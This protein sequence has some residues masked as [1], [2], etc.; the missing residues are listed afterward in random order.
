MVEAGNNI[1]DTAWRLVVK[2]PGGTAMATANPTA[3]Q[4]EADDLQPRRP[5]RRWRLPKKALVLVLGTAIVLLLLAR[6]DWSGFYTRGRLKE[7]VRYDAVNGLRHTRSVSGTRHLYAKAGQ[8]IE[9][10]YQAILTH[11]TLHITV[12]Q[13]GSPNHRVAKRR[14][15][16]SGTGGLLV[17]V[18]VTGG[19]RVQV[20][21]TS[22][23]HGLDV[24]YDVAWQVR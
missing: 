11:G 3:W 14:V 22:G 8:Q 9:V 12:Y 17:P 15:T 4:L 2:E 10:N 20:G 24:S 23:P 18:P 6:V 5:R 1:V 19:Y 7:Q 21:W 16:R 13:G